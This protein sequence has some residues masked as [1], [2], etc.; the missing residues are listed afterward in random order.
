AKR[1][2]A[3]HGITDQFVYIDQEPNTAEIRKAMTALAA[4][5]TSV[6]QIWINQKHVGG[7]DDL[8]ALD[9]TGDLGVALEGIPR[10]AP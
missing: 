9:K 2:L 4:N 7:C 6:P 3:G 1:A 5:R 8:K 10:P